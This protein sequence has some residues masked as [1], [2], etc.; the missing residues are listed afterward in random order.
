MEL[1]PSAICAECGGTCCRRMWFYTSD[2]AD[3]IRYDW[4]VTDLITVEAV[5]EGELWK[6]AI[7]APCRQFV[8]NGCAVHNAPRPRY[9]TGYPW[10]YLTGEVE[11][12]VIEHEARACPLLLQLLHLDTIREDVTPD[13]LPTLVLGH[14][15]HQSR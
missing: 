8:N 12:A 10:N 7:E 6:V 9:C 1:D 14:G 15:V 5:I 13:G 11:R 4:L 3:A 2:A